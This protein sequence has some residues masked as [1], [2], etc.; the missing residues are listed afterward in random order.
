[1][2]KGKQ[3]L[4]DLVEAQKLFHLRH[5]GMGCGIVLHHFRKFTCQ[6]QGLFLGLF[7]YI[8]RCFR[9][10]QKCPYDR[11]EQKQQNECKHCKKYKTNVFHI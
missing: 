7:C 10:H 11:Y 3:L 9:R 4:Q 1:M 5:I 6:R 2:H 8:G